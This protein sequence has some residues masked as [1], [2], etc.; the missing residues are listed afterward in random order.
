MYIVVEWKQKFIIK[1][2]NGRRKEDFM[3]A[4]ITGEYS[5]YKKDSFMRGQDKVEY[6]QICIDGVGNYE[7]E[8]MIISVDL[9]YVPEL[10]KHNLYMFE[11]NLDP[12]YKKRAR[13]IGVVPFD[14][15][16][17]K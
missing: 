8:R 1:T 15:N 2:L 13:L 17:K 10:V 9:S 11:V 12:T 4:V 14:M 7:T 6:A 16:D 5:G 3:K